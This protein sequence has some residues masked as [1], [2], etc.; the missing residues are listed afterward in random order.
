[1][2]SRIQS[3][4]LQQVPWIG[5]CS[6]RILIGSVMKDALLLRLLCQIS[7]MHAGPQPLSPVH[8]NKQ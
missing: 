7:T 2:S 3:Q 5:S 4:N 8:G 6:Y 1:M